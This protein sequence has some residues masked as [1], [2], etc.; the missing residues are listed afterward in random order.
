VAIEGLAAAST[1]PVSIPPGGTVVLN[2]TPTAGDVVVGM[3]RF[4][5]DFPAG[6]VVRFRF[7]GGQVGVLNAPV[8]PFATLVLNT[9][10]GNDTGVA[11]AN[12]GSS[13]INLRLVHVDESGKTVEVVEPREL[14]P[15]P[16]NGQVAKFVTQFGF[17]RIANRS[18]GSV[19]IQVK[20]VG[21][22]QSAGGGSEKGLLLDS[23]A[24]GFSAFA[25][26]LRDGV[27]SSTSVVPG[28]S[29]NAT[30]GQFARSYSGEWRANDYPES[31]KVYMSLSVNTATQMVVVNLSLEPIRYL[32][33]DER[34]RSTPTTLIG[35]FD[36]NGF[37]ATENSTF[38]GS[39]SM[40]IDAK[41]RWTFTAN[42]IPDTDGE[43]GTFRITGVA[44]P[45]RITGDFVATY[46]T[47]DPPFTGKITLNHAAQ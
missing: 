38:F 15:L 5:S 31:G 29:G 47:G 9:N 45:D 46:R 4:V 37:T 33:S 35:K 11:I 21:L 24:G 10:D 41:G 6:G 27:L 28:V 8:T 42:D 30:L 36:P 20:G 3:A 19:Q 39:V 17:T 40:T 12:P 34:E 44:Y 25:L 16:P 32:W 2:T 23:G 26:L 14:N 1:F 22:A 18:S 43:V 13:P 7:S